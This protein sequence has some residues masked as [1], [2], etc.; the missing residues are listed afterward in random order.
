MLFSDRSYNLVLFLFILPIYLL[1]YQ[2]ITSGDGLLH[3]HTV[4]NLFKTGSFSLPD[5]IYGGDKQLKAFMKQGRDGK[6]YSSLPPGLSLASIPLG[7]IG[8][9]I[10]HITGLDTKFA[11]KNMV[12]EK[13]LENIRKIPSAFMV[14]LTNTI[15]M[16][17]ALVFF[18]NLTRLLRPEAQGY[19]LLLTLVCGFGTIV[20]PYAVTYWTQALDT[21]CLM[22][23]LF[24]LMN[25][26][27]NKNN[28]SLLAA[29]ILSG[30]SVLSRYEAP[31]YLFWL[32][33]F[34]AFFL[35]QERKW[36][37][38]IIYLAPIIVIFLLLLLWNQYRFGSLWDTGSALSGNVFRAFRGDIGTSLPANLFSLHRSVFLYS[39]PALFFFALIFYFKK[40]PYFVLLIILLVVTNVVFFSKF[41]FWS[42]PSS[43]GPRYQ[44]V[45]VPLMVLPALFLLDGRKW[46]PNVLCV[47]AIAGLVVQLVGVLQP[48]QLDTKL[49]ADYWGADYGNPKSFYSKSDMIIQF[50]A[51]STEGAKLWWMDSNAVK[52]AA[53]CLAIVSLLSGAVLAKQYKTELCVK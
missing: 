5:E 38:I 9:A 18:F 33:A 3:Y 22:G 10:D 42:A 52:I 47:L 29:G 44:V 26:L 51:L 13:Y 30:F 41:F 14:G 37:K 25:F 16:S 1:T 40:N 6:I 19:G 15:L 17:L 31:I 11:Y 48:L 50:K 20:W 45:V 36:Q 46:V 24:Y 35:V 27:K 32:T 28:G 53:V 49:C 7:A 39:P 34:T 21:F 23:S 4:Q 2:G 12:D 43:W 8:F